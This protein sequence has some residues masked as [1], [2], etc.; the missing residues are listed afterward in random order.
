MKILEINKFHYLR[1]GGAKHFLNVSRLLEKRGHSVARFSMKHPE[2]IPNNWSKYFVSHVGYQPENNFWQKLKGLGRIFYSFEAK[3]KIRK[4]LKEFRP[5]IVHLHSI[6]HQISPSILKE[7]KRMGVPIVMT[8]HD[9]KLIYPDRLPPVEERKLNEDKRWCY[10]NFIKRKCFK[11]SYLKSFLVVLETKI[12]QWTKI[13]D[14]HIDLY[15][16]P[17]NFVK[18]ALVTN[19]LSAK[20]IKVL[21]HFL[22]LKELEIVQNHP[23]KIDR[24]AEKDEYFFYFGRISN[25]KGAKE[26][27]E[28]FKN[29]N[30]IKL[31]IAGRIFD[32]IKIPS[33]KNIRYLGF[34]SPEKIHYYIKNSLAVVSP[35]RIMET[36]GLVLMETHIQGKP[37]IGLDAGAY[38]EGVKEGQN[39][40][41]CKNM[42]DFEKVIKEVS[43]QKYIF[44]NKLIKKEA[45]KMYDSN[46]YYNKL[47]N[48]FEKL[49]KNN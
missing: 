12:N 2:N 45:M 10:I 11:N 20:K 30:N 16:A 6:Y 46:K 29:N 42:N 41:I 23:K 35:S 9:F 17:R 38:F 22:N 5:D 1:G 3:F 36:F 4:L 43:Q 47:I 48:I 26:L 44:N 15:I 7:I 13:Y 24:Q 40:F 14:K 8:V 31:Y 28:I 18:E 34:L 27:I 32:G 25:E 33:R 21:P 19:G 49:I 37:F 39:G